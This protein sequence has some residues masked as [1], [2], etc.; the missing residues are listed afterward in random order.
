MAYHT[1]E[2]VLASA[3]EETQVS[4]DDSVR[5]ASGEIAPCDYNNCNL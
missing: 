3:W 4:I 1:Q 5:C 2:Q